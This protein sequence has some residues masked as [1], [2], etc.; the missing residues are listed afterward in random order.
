MNVYPYRTK[1]GYTSVLDAADR[2][3]ARLWLKVRYGRGVR[4]CEVSN[5]VVYLL[6]SSQFSD[7]RSEIVDSMLETNRNFVT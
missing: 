6:H 5:S 7:D 2:R 1:G 4:F 3:D